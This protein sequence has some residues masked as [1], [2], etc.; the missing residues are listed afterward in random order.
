MPFQNFAEGQWNYALG[1]NP[2]WVPYI[3][4]A[5]PNSP[6]NPHDAKSSGGNDIGNIDTDPVNSVRTL[7]GAIVGG[8]NKQDKYWNIRSDWPETEVSPF[9]SSR[10]VIIFV[11]KTPN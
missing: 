5:N 8:P 2:M 1:K 10:P 11:S 4:G 6:T 3:V 7:Y 9:F